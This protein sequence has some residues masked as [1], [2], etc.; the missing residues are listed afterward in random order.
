[1][2]LKA[3]TVDL[4]D[5][6]L[7]AQVNTENRQPFW[8]ELSDEE[9]AQAPLPWGPQ[10][11]QALNRYA[12]V[13][14]NPL[15]WTDPAGYFIPVCGIE[16]LARIRDRAT[17]AWDSFWN[18]IAQAAFDWG[19]SVGYKGTD[20]QIRYIK[21][22]VKQNSG[23][24]RES[25]KL[26]TTESETANDL[27][28]QFLNGNANPGLGNKYLPNTDIF[29]LRA[30]NGTRVFMRKIG[31][32]SYEILAYANKDNETRVIRMLYDLYRR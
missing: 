2:A 10:N 16:C 26:N 23:L 25:R 9:R 12:Y 8:F 4:R 14:N 21:S 11:P 28:N 1:V 6:A 20:G 22:S 13:L 17:E 24:L 15:R 32:N 7:L 19:M 3:L 30:R 5:P 27:V 31:E 29:Y 18:Q